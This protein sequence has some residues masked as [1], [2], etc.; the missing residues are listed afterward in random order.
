MEVEYVALSTSCKDLFLII[1]ITTK[2]CLA[3]EIPLQK[4]VN[5]HVKIHEDNVGALTLRRLEPQQM[6]PCSK[7]YTVKY[8]WFCEHIGPWQINIGK[9]AS[10]AQ[11]RDLFT[12]GLC[13]VTFERLQKK[14]V[15][16]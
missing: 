9:I 8:H 11:L 1:D 16:W 2:L 4:G 15:G 3:L 14:I 5:L 6:T 12:K 13:R 10:E 7:H